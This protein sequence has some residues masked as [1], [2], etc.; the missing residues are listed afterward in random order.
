MPFITEELWH[1]LPRPADAP[2]TVVLARYPRPEDE[3]RD[4]AAETAIERLIAVVRALRNLRAETNLPPAS[5]IDVYFATD[6]PAAAEGVRAFAAEIRALAKIRELT[7][8][9]SADRPRGAAVAV[10]AGIELYVPLAGLIDVAAER[11]RLARE[12]ERT[13]KDLDGVSRKLENDDFIARAPADIVAKERAKAA[14]LE[15]KRQLLARGLE[16]LSELE[17]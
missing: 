2:E 4:D 11:S 13:A 16:R 10:A 3:Q 14:E 9:S 8:T 12:I 1:A 17:E 6:D 7:S 15:G 5:E